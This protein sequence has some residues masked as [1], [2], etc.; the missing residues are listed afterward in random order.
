MELQLNQHPLRAQQLLR[1]IPV[2]A[3]V[4]QQPMFNVEEQVDLVL[5]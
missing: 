3:V 1:I 4:V 2:V 5:L